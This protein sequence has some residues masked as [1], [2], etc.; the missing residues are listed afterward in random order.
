MDIESH[1][2]DVIAALGYLCLGSRFKRLGERLQTD[3]LG[4]VSKRS[5]TVLPGQLPFLAA[6]DRLG[7]LTIG[8]MAQAVGISQPGATKSLLQLIKK[9]L[10]TVKKSHEDRRVRVA[11]LTTAGSELVAQSKADVWVEVEA[12]ARALCA[13]LNGT[14]L[15]QLETIE[16]RLGE[17]P[18]HRWSK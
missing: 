2:E 16:K 9:G 17:K 11:M 13:D 1:K 8:E 3:T 5:G 7:P 15:E 12:A 4:I 10:I 18:L 6:L 14:I